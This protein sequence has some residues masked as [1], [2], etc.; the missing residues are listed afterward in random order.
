MRRAYVLVER[1]G[2]RQKIAKD[3]T[4]LDTLS[5]DVR[6]AV[7]RLVGTAGNAGLLG[8]RDHLID[9]ATN[10]E[11]ASQIILGQPQLTDTHDAALDPTME[12]EFM[13]FRLRDAAGMRGE[14]EF[15]DSF[16]SQ[17]LPLMR[18]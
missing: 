5:P 8:D 10:K 12:A 16:N 14:I 7:G 18:R 9:N 3:P 2:G 4:L 11:T 13:Y 1:L 15:M 17:V 6:S